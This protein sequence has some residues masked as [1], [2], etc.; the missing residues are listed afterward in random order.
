MGIIRSQQE[1]SAVSGVL[2][3]A[4]LTYVAAAVVP[5]GVAAL[6]PSALLLNR[7]E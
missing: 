1:M 2:S 7:E 6:L 3:A 4:A 5:S